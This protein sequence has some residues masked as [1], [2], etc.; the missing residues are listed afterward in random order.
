[1]APEQVTGT[2]ADQRT[3]I[4]ALGAV[5]FEA[6]TGRRA[7][8]GTNT[9][10][11]IA[12]IMTAN[13]PNI[14]TCRG[15]TPPA[16]DRVVNKCLAKDPE[17]RWQNAGDL[18]TALRWVNEPVDVAASFRRHLTTRADVAPDG[19]GF[20]MIRR[21]DPDTRIHVILNWSDELKRRVSSAR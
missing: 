9:A 12:A 20:L 15:D 17:A 7:F 21:V 8:S 6:V 1:M 18:A 14:S 3:D 2:A 13:P 11:L 10:E 16:L 19:Q 4:F 5:L